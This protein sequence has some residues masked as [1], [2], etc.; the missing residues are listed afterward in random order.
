[1]L[2]AIGSAPDAGAA[3]RAQ[4][5]LAAVPADER[6]R[7][8]VLM[9]GEAVLALFSDDPG[10]ARAAI[11]R[12][13]VGAEAWSRA[14]LLLLRA[15][16]AE[17]DGDVGSMRADLT[18]A[19]AGFAELHERWG[20]GTVL[21]ALGSV[22]VTEG[23]TG[24]ALE[25]YERSLRYMRELNAD[26]DVSHVMIS[27]ALAKVRTGDLLGARTELTAVLAS[28][29]DDQ[30]LGFD[31]GFATYGLA[32]VARAE[33]DLVEARRLGEESLAVLRPGAAAPQIRGFVESGLALLDIEEGDLG[34]ARERLARALADVTP[35]RDMPVLARVAV[36]AAALLLAAGDARRAADLL[37]VARQLRG[38]D[39]VGDPDLNR[40]A[41]EVTSVLGSRVAGARRA[42]WAGAPRGDAL[43]HL[44]ALLAPAPEPVPAPRS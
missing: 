33:G 30:R 41:A 6:A 37:G 42:S 10:R 2:S 19:Y 34:A 14:T 15:L 38:T 24:R 13:L 27:I 40:V 9:M 31:V 21:S 35:T 16:V 22:H 17:N 7:H 5:V 25:A 44:A 1:V 8:P 20:M 36:A 28:A 39:D 4:L 29:S 3:E 32:E 43:A 11:D 23:D 26:E 12:S 18:A